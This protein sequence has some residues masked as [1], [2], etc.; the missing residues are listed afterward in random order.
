[1]SRTKQPR[2][3]LQNGRQEN[4]ATV[5]YLMMGERLPHATFSAFACVGDAGSYAHLGNVVATSSWMY[6]R[7]SED[8]HQLSTQTAARCQTMLALCGMS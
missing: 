8:H 6:V 5:R 2:A 4:G 7:P 1:M 3:T